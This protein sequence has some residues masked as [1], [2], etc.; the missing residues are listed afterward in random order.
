MATVAVV[1]S[2]GAATQVR[3]GLRYSDNRLL[4]DRLCQRPQCEF[5]PVWIISNDSSGS[6]FGDRDW[7]NDRSRRP[8]P[9]PHTK[10]YNNALEISPERFLGSQPPKHLVAT[11]LIR[12]LK[13]ATN[14]KSRS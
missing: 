14:G 3:G 1:E 13:C 6:L 11:L 5:F 2:S 9:V 10:H 7:I 4:R 8:I 12:S